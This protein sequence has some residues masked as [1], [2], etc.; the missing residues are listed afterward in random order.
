MPSRLCEGG[1]EGRLSM[2]IAPLGIIAGGGRVPGRIA[3]AAAAAGRSVFI[4]GLE[5]FADASVLAPW[6][7]EMI[8]IGAAGRIL[9]ALRARACRDIVL[10][11][12]VRRPSIFA[13]R[14]DTE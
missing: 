8:R 12:P 1:Q 7:H 11:G 3:T 14:P 2:T 9:A 6:P 5:G 13:L 10:I 4:V